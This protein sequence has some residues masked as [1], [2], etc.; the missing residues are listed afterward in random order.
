MSRR[1][2]QS[3]HEIP[4]DRP[5]YIKKQTNKHRN[6]Q[7]PQPENLKILKRERSP[8][9]SALLIVT[10][11]TRKLKIFSNSLKVVPVVQKTHIIS[12]LAQLSQGE[13]S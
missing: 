7:E 1:T 12:K 4:A 6:Q 13:V 3:R 9:S 11:K 8:F 5:L 2:S 10:V